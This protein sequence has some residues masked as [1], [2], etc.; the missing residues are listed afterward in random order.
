[1]ETLVPQESA[2]G[3]WTEEQCFRDMVESLVAIR[4]EKKKRRL[5]RFPTPAALSG[6]FQ[7]SGFNGLLVCDEE[8]FSAFPA[9]SP[10]EARM[11]RRAAD[12]IRRINVVDFCEAGVQLKLSSDDLQRLEGRSLHL[13]VRN[14]RLPVRLAW[15]TR[16][17]LEYQGG[18]SFVGKIDSDQYLARFIS[19]LNSYLIEF[20]LNKY[21]DDPS[22]FGRQAGIFIYFAICYGLRLRFLETAAEI[23]SLTTMAEAEF[24]DAARQFV[25]RAFRDYHYSGVYHREQI[26]RNISDPRLKKLLHL[27]MKP[28]YAFGCGVP[29]LQET[30]VFLRDDA[31]ATILNSMLFAKADCRA[32]TRFLPSFLSLHQHFL[33]LKHLLP[34]VL[35]D[36]EFGNQFRYYSRIISEME[37]LRERVV[38]FVSTQ[39]VRQL[40]SSAKSTSL[41]PGGDAPMDE[42]SRE[43]PESG[44]SAEKKTLKVLLILLLLLCVATAAFFCGLWYGR[45]TKPAPATKT[46]VQKT[47]PMAQVHDNTATSK[48]ADLALS[49]RGKKTAGREQATTGDSTP[50]RDGLPSSVPVEASQRAQTDVPPEGESQRPKEHILE[51]EAVQDAWV[52]V[53]TDNRRT[54]GELLKAGEK[55]KWEASRSMQIVLGNA[56]GVRMK[57][58]GAPLGPVGKPGEPVRFE[59]PAPDPGMHTRQ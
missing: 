37:L 57:W 54:Y 50:S 31:W 48:A 39:R 52:Q 30:S 9:G 1:M 23:N 24:P 4:S 27:Y 18:F 49:D 6:R 19:S 47:E 13:E 5:P 26:S 46:A 2:Y 34:G 3:E 28:Y 51:M 59:L 20:L 10:E 58:D 43:F 35:D 53:K 16:S 14:F 45:S 25:R 41:R 38:D 15:W 56:G 17:D 42:A 12:R 33:D 8:D 22:S 44:A 11:P 29:G 32:S 21:R 36:E 55:R 7:F 40:S